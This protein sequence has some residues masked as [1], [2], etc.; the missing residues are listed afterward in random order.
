[1]ETYKAMYYKLFNGITDIVA[2][3]EKSHSCKPAEIEHII[4][5]LKQLQLDAEEIFINNSTL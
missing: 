4:F 1:M 2:E 3:L 5:K